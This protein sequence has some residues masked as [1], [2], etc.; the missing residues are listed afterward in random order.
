MTLSGSNVEDE[1]GITYRQLDYWTR[2]GHLHPL[3]DV[4]TGIAR[5]WT[6]AE[7]EIARRMGRLTAAGVP[8]ERAATFARNTWPRGEIAPGIVIEVTA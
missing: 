4:G 8:V 1:L 3:N 7:L 5:E 2:K 6:E